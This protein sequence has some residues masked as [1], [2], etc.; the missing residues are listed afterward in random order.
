MSSSHSMPLLDRIHATDNQCSK[1]IMQ[2]MLDKK[3][4]LAVAADLTHAEELL[5]LVE[6]IGEHICILKTHI[7]IIADF[8]PALIDELQ[9]L[10][11]KYNFLIFEDR[12]FADIGNTVEKQYAEGIYK[13]AEWADIINAHIIPGPGIIE[14][15][16]NA[17]I[18][19]K[20]GLLLLAEMS[21]QGNL[22]KNDYA[23]VA[24]QWAQQYNDFVCGFIAQRRLSNDPGMLTLTPGVNLKP[25]E[26]R[27]QQRY[28]SPEQVLASG[29]DIV[30][31][32]R[33]IYQNSDPALEANKY[34]KI[35]AKL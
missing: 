27:L 13:I 14:G 4:R 9:H 21:S 26:G 11:K 33:D 23:H 15:L 16:R 29:S 18:D 28:R 3:S 12:K 17:R 35:L 31:V 22:L 6:R 5:N 25:G 1:N 7:D 10:Q 2:T 30:I 19:K 32:G 24:C 20:Q 8:G 34:Q